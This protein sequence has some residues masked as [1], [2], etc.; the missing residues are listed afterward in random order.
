MRPRG[1]EA[2]AEQ[3]PDKVVATIGGKSVTAKEAANLLK[4]LRPEDRKRLEGNLP[5][6]VQQIYAQMQMA[7]QAADMKLGEQP[8]YKEQL[9]IARANI[10][11]QAYLAKMA[12]NGGMQDPKTYYDAHPADFDQIKLS[13]IF[14]S[15]NQPGTPASSSA[16]QRAEPQAREK[17]NDIEKKIKAGGDFSTLARTESD[18]QQ[19]AARGGELGTFIMADQNLPPDVK[20]TIENMQTGQVSEPVRVQGGFYIFKVDNRTKLPFEQVRTKIVQK[21]QNEKSQQILKQE[22]AKYKVDVQDPDFFNVSTAAPTPTLRVPSLQRP[23]PNATPATPPPG[24][25]K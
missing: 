22:L 9:E 19:A 14:I 6:L 21:L 8:P 3:T 13:G 12:Q 2:V 23:S 4:P 11:A 5:N 15:F 18:N 7:K 1:P 16:I 24:Q 17:A 10:L 20:Q 25:P